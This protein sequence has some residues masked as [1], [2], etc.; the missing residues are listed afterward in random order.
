[1][2]IQ[3]K[4][5]VLVSR[6]LGRARRALGDATEVLLILEALEVCSATIGLTYRL[7]DE[8]YAQAPQG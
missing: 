2:E 7:P 5:A 6:S 4:A 8:R 3:D 1:M